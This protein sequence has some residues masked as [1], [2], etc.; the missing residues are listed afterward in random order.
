[1]CDNRSKSRKGAV[2]RLDLAVNPDPKCIENLQLAW[3]PTA[4]C[5]CPVGVEI[6]G[7]FYIQPGLVTVSGGLFWPH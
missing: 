4:A 5:T 2:K 3:S 1:M 7:P 6:Q